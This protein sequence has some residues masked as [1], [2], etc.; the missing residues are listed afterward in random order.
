MMLKDPIIGTNNI[1]Y[2]IHGV[3]LESKHITFNTPIMV[4]NPTDRMFAQ[5]LTSNNFTN[6]CR[7][8]VSGWLVDIN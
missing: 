1:F 8:Y 6:V 5:N 4:I 2:K 7:V 3:S